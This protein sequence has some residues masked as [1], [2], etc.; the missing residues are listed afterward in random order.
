MRVPES[1]LTCQCAFV[2]C[3]MQAGFECYL[4]PAAHGSIKLIVTQLNVG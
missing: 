1:T 4:P 2:L 3:S